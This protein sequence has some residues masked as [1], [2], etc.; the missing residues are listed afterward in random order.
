MKSGQLAAG[1]VLLNRYEIIRFHTSGSMQ[2]VYFAF[3]HALNRQVILK[4]PKDKVKD[5]RFGRGAT[6]GARVNHPNVAATFDYYEDENITFMI[7]ELIHGCDLAKRLQQDFFFLDPALAAHVIHHIVRALRE[8]HRVGICHRDLKP[9]NIMV[10]DDY[11]LSSIKLTDFGIAKMAESEIDAEMKLFGKNTATLTTSSTLLGAI[12]YLAPECWVDWKSAGQ[13]MDIWALGC[14]AFELLAG[15]PPFG[16][17]YPA[18]GRVTQVQRDGN[19]TLT[20]PSWFG[21]HGVSAKLEDD[22][23]VILM[24][25][26]EVAP[27]KRPT[28]AEVLKMCDSLCYATPARTTGVVTQYPGSYSSGGV[29]K[30]GHIREDQTGA[31]HFFHISAYYGKVHPTPNQRVSFSVYPG[32]P[33]PRLSPV[34]LLNVA[35]G[36]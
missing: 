32:A 20:K 21:T 31:D 11:A 14:I 2:D 5:K 16:T 33:R 19:V 23:W 24:S 8:A 34:L 12:P 18:I 28:A 35:T 36:A 17:G 3:D 1:D 29:G 15:S 26:L 9:S 13:P 22:L 25:C 27:N 30:F 6:M 7:E 10:S 4:A